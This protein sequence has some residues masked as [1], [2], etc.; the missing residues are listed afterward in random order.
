M[1]K[2]PFLTLF[3]ALLLGWPARGREPQ[4]QKSETKPS[5]AAS[6]TQAPATK[7]EQDDVVRITTSLVQLDAV[8]TKDGKQITDLTADDFE[9]S[10]DGRP[11]TITHFSYISNVPAT[12]EVTPNNAPPTPQPRTSTASVLPAVIRSRETRRTI[13]IVVDDL[14]ISLESMSPVKHQLRKFVDE[15]LQP[16][17]LVAIIR[18]GGEVGSLQQFTTDR[19]L[20]Y[21]AIESL[22]WN[23][24]SRVGNSALAPAPNLTVPSNTLG[25]GQNAVGLCAN[26]HGGPLKSTVR[27]LRF[28]L[29]GMRD[30]PGRKSMVLLS[31]NL[32]LDIP[33]LDSLERGPIG[34][35]AP[36]SDD[37]NADKVRGIDE[38][39]FGNEGVLRRT[40]EIAN[41]S[42]V[43]IYS[44]DTRGIKATGITAT[45]N[46]TP[47]G[48]GRPG[49]PQSVGTGYLSTSALSI[50]NNRK[51]QMQDA[52]GGMSLLARQTG[53]FLISNTNDFGLPRVLLDQEGYYLI[54][55]R[56]SAETFNRAFHNIKVRVKH[57][58]LTLRTREGF[59]GLTDKEVMP[60][61]PTTRDQLNSALMSPFGKVEIDLRM[62]ALFAN[63]KSAGS[64]VRCLLH[65]PADALSF[66]AES[67]G[68]RKAKFSLSGILFGDNGGVV[69]QV[70][71][72][73][74][75]RL[76]SKD[77]DRALR[78]GLVYQLD[79]Q[80]KKPGS[81]Q[82][83]AAVQDATSSK[84]GTA[85]QIVE[86]PDFRTR[87]L[88]ISG[89][90]IS[91]G[92]PSPSS[93]LSY[94]NSAGRSG[95]EQETVVNIGQLAIRRLRQ[96]SNLFYAYVIYMAQVDKT[97]SSPRLT[98]EARIFHDGKLIYAGGHKAIDTARQ[99]DLDRI[100]ASGG[101]Q[102]NSLKP[103]E[104]ILQ[105]VVK[106]RFA[107]E[108]LGTA[109]QWID[110]EIVP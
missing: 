29:Q 7:D 18:T 103:G 104:Y 109:T 38:T 102:I 58:G 25:T 34:P 26:V 12:A 94:Q 24:C 42:S 43:V 40:A 78:E 44:V 93:E 64:A 10:E 62:T 48:P 5:K 22:S 56:P 4:T 47:S 30:L 75:L 8:V 65:F 17:D 110:F 32:P 35:Q 36:G 96:N 76:N 61:K 98:A 82:F 79:L 80:V 106:D 23:L 21:R 50:L 14:G 51:A 28:I 60:N 105:I 66:S 3:V 27:A 15:Q 69:D 87:R 86:I 108:K 46:L 33:D 6:S 100:S 59:F 11:Q 90:T 71:E 49:S 52:R 39:H 83:R 70:S 45:D 95:G 20:L 63:T 107:D 99:A 55:Y 31:D 9:I 89:I 91:T 13:A 92:G 37:P 57:P 54:G 16:N 97:T 74:T 85:G 67:G 101:L 72:T 68:A 77:Y 88:A 84:I 53:G 19:R 41:R 73:R 81:Y 2:R 1:S